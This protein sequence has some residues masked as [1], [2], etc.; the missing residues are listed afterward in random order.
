MTEMSQRGN[1]ATRRRLRYHHRTF[2]KRQIGMGW[3]TLDTRTLYENPW[4]EL[5]EDSVINP[6]GGRN[7]YGW[8][9]FRNRAVAMIPIDE[10]GNTWLIGQDRF[11]LG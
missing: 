9:H 5:R 2:G 3:T 7:E 6:R 10:D 11:T 4:M 1:A 8:V